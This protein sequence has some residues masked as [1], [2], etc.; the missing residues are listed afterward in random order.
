MTE[1]TTDPAPKAKPQKRPETRV[2]DAVRIARTSD[3]P[4]SDF[5]NTLSAADPISVGD[6]Q[7]ARADAEAAAIMARARVRRDFAREIA[8]LDAVSLAMVRAGISAQ[9]PSA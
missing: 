2:R 3:V 9:L 5:S 4:L 6:S 7:Y 1:P 8:G